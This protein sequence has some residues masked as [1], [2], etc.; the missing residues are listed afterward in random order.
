MARSLAHPVRH[1]IVMALSGGRTLAARELAKEIDEP[2][3]T[4]R[5]HLSELRKAGLVSS[6]KS[7]ARRGVAEHYYRSATLPTVSEEQHELMTPV[8]RMRISSSVL[9]YSF[10]D[11]ASAL[12][13]GTLDRRSSR[14]LSFVR[15]PL[16]ERGW[17]ELAAIHARAHSE[18]ER[19]KAEA[20]QRLRLNGKKPICA[21][22]VLLFFE[23]PQEPA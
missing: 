19:V 23:R 18:V 10:A 16:D 13:A 14:C 17:T 7:V 22:S 2:V 15:I 20:G 9:K 21:T 12:K 4:V 11:V 3:R 1:K 5:H 8:E 6:E